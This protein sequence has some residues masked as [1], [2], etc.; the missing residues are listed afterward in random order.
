MRI[1][2]DVTPGEYRAAHDLMAYVLRRVPEDDQDS[3]DL[4]AFFR[5]L[6]RSKNKILCPEC[7]LRR[8][9]ARGKCEPCYREA[10]RKAS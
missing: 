10:K 4:R 3:A 7:R 8:V 5:K 6:A 2:I 9:Y 1:V